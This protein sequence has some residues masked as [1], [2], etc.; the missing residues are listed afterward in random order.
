MPAPKAVTTNTT[1]TA[2]KASTM[3]EADMVAA[4]WS[5]DPNMDIFFYVIIGLSYAAT[6]IPS[7]AGLPAIGILRTIMFWYLVYCAIMS[8]LDLDKKPK[9]EKNIWNIN[10]WLLYALRRPIV[11]FLLSYIIAPC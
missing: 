7:V 11:E 1:T 3:S 5:T 9:A 8:F 6:I 2:P 10:N 4:A